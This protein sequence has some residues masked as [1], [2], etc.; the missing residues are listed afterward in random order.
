MLIG[1]DRA[2]SFVQSQVGG[3]QP[4]P[5]AR[6]VRLSGGNRLKEL[7]RGGGLTRLQGPQD[8]IEALR[9]VALRGR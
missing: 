9:A 6:V 5:G 3:P 8:R 1:T 7:G 4:T 2:T